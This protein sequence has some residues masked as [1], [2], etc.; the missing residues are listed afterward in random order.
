MLTPPASAA[1]VLVRRGLIALTGIGGLAT[2]FELATERHWN[3]LEQLIPWLALVVLAAAIALVPVRRGR[4]VAV[5]RVL[6]LLVLGASA[7]GVV[8]HILVNYNSGVLDQ[9]YAETW[10]RLPLAHRWW[11]AV[12]KSVGPAPT[13]A[14]GVLGQSALLLLLATFLGDRPSR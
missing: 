2:A 6:A 10:D 13:L 11:L 8:D 14:P 7:Y 5:A 3:G 12:T 4:A 9:R 1:P